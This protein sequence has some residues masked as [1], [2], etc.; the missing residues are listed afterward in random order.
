MWK[1]VHVKSIIGQLSLFPDKTDDGDRLWKLIFGSN[2]H[3]SMNF[4]PLWPKMHL[5]CDTI[6]T[7]CVR[8]NSII[9]PS[10][11]R[12]SIV[13]VYW[14]KLPAKQTNKWTENDWKMKTKILNDHMT[15]TVVATNRY[16]KSITVEL[17]EYFISVSHS[18]TTDDDDDFDQFLMQSIRLVMWSMV[19]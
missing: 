8:H 6:N 11:R 1:I 5:K 15:I 17:C 10:C 14:L 12:Q 4:I 18:N 16:H 7:I 9:S 2:D 19:I 3:L 13:S